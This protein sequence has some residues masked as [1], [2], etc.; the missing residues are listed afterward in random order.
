[1]RTDRRAGADRHDGFQGN[2]CGRGRVRR[3]TGH[4]YRIDPLGTGTAPEHVRHAPHRR[5]DPTGT[6]R[7]RCRGS[8]DGERM[9]RTDTAATGGLP[10]SRGC[11]GSRERSVELDIAGRWGMMLLETPQDTGISEIPPR[12]SND[13]VRSPRDTLLTHAPAEGDAP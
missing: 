3:R 9:P 5:L 2:P 13:V 1:R 4:E 6:T 11:H 8:T 10:L 12:G 7:H